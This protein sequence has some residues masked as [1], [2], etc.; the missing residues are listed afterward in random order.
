MT[1][2]A[3]VKNEVFLFW[4]LQAFDLLTTLVGFQLGAHETNIFIRQFF[5]LF[6]LIGGLVI[7]K[8]FTSLVLFFILTFVLVR[9]KFWTLAVRCFVVLICW[10]VA[11]ILIQTLIV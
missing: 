10:N 9:P 3:P 2:L 7:A 8:L 5:P 6:G 11:M 1:S 4:M